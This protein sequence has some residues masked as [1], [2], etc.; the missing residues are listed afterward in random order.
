MSGY[1]GRRG[2]N[3]SQYLNDLNA[4]PSLFE[5]TAQQD[6]ELCDVS[7]DLALFTNAEFLDYDSKGDMSDRA[8]V[9]F[10][11]APAHADAASAQS[12]NYLDMLSDFSIPSYQYPP[13][14]MVP[15]PAPAYSIAPPVQ[16]ISKPVTSLSPGPVDL[17]L[18]QLA[19]PRIQPNNGA[20]RKQDS[21]ILDESAR[22]AQEEDK[23]RRNTAASARF[24]VK[25][26]E[27]E[28]TLERTVKDVTSK[29]T[30]LEARVSELEL[31]NRWLKN[32][33]TE[34]NGTF[35]SD[36]EIS[37]LLNKFQESKDGQGVKT[38]SSELPSSV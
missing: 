5:Q 14:P 32:L 11:D 8:P 13:P 1:N 37:S 6:H 4:V 16:P 35:L 36:N 9:A 17:S 33:I 19:Q 20:K 15:V 34:K 25:K 26:K 27:R 23:R 22:L 30:A 29:N 2:P 7:A 21:P 28:K 38:E 3:F 12:M 24:R 10:A 18:V 31:E